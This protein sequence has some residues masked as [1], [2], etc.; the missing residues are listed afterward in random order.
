MEIAAPRETFERP[1]NYVVSTC[2]SLATRFPGSLWRGTCPRGG[3]GNY[4]CRG[5]GTA[6]TALGRA[7]AQLTI[8]PKR[9]L[10]KQ[11]IFTD[12][13]RITI[14]PV[15][16]SRLGGQYQSDPWLRT[17]PHFTNARPPFVQASL[18]ACSALSHPVCQ[19]Q[20]SKLLRPRSGHLMLTSCDA[21]HNGC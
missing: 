14:G 9:L 15:A 21:P 8:V 11:T 16:A 12:H 4:R 2:I 6:R 20:R 1:P 13:H 18:G 10:A 7:S 17:G 19:F 5:R 3:A